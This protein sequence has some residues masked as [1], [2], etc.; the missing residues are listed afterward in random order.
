MNVVD[1]SKYDNSWYRP[2]SRLKILIW[3]YVNAVFIKSSLIF[4]SRIKVLVLRAFGAKIG[5]NVTIKPGVSVK[6]P[7]KLIVEDYVGIG[8][9]VWIDNLA[10]VKIGRQTTISQGALLLTGSHDHSK[11]TFDLIVGD[12]VIED[13][14]WIGA[15]AM[16]CQNVTC[17]SHSMLAAGSLAI[18]DLNAYQ[19]YGGSPAKIIKERV[20]G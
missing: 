20:G 15:N 11:S 6:Y 16:V 4:S 1:K 8:E 7:W 10:F 2:G 13:G 9:N 12:I 19:I 3:F 14:V 17:K 5:A 18:T